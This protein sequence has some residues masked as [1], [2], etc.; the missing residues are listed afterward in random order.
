MQVPSHSCLRVTIL[1]QHHSPARP[2]QNLD[3]TGLFCAM[4]AYLIWGFLPLFFKQMDGVPPLE[5]VA[6]RVIWAVPLL[7]IIMW[8]RK[9][10]PE[11]FGIFRQWN[12]LRWMFL[13][14]FLI[15]INWLIY[16]W[17]VNNG[18]IVGASLGYYLNPLLNILAGTMFLGERLNRQQWLAVGIAAFA[19]AI[20]AVGA[21]GTLWIS[22]TLAS[23]FCLYGLVRKTAP[24]GAVPGL[25]IETVLLFPAAFF[26]AAYVGEN[27]PASGWAAGGMIMALLIS[28]GVITAVPLLLFATAARRMNYSVLGF[29]QYIA[30]TI[31]FFLGIFLY[32]EKLSPI[33]LAAF[34]LIWLALAIFSWDALRRLR[35]TG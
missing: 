24:V 6:Q 13:T 14:A 1:D 23:S 22:L 27:D 21:F 18:Q 32:G 19:V 34:A 15:S 5:I 7:I 30:P 4:G 2:E 20:L 31:Q 35:K 3:R 10:L 12:V 17:A 26:A 33:R 16:V 28:G 25:A 11:F 8:F 29:I 9:Q